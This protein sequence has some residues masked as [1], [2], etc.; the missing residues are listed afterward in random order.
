MDGCQINRISNITNQLYHLST[1]SFSKLVFR[2]K[3]RFFYFRY[4]IFL[5]FYS[6]RLEGKF[7]EISKMPN[8]VTLDL[9]FN[10]I[11]GDLPDSISNL[12]YL[13]YLNVCNNQLSGNISSLQNL[14]NLQTIALNNNYVSFH[15]ITIIFPENSRN[16]TNKFQRDFHEDSRKFPRKF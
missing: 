3:I 10:Y 4:Q 2:H 1:L 12:I 5:T 7:P 16:C 15:H 14:N 13:E 9:S 8:L 11:G 6:N